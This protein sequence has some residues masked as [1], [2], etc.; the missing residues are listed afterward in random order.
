MRPTSIVIDTIL[1]SFRRGKRAAFVD[2][3]LDAPVLAFTCVVVR[4]YTKAAASLINRKQIG[5]IS[6]DISHYQELSIDALHAG[7]KTAYQAQG[8]IA[9]FGSHSTDP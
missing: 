6:H 4:E 3:P 7:A 8:Q 9:S 5:K 2:F 1:V